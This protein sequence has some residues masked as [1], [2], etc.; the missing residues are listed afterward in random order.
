MQE[1][2]MTNAIAKSTSAESSQRIF[3]FLKSHSIGTLATVDSDNNPHATTIYFS[4]DEAFNIFF[5]TK[6]FTKKHETLQHNNH[7]M[8]VTHEAFT[9]TTAQVIGVAEEVVDT[10]LAEQIF[11]ETIKNA[12]KSTEA[13]VPPI[14]KL[15]AGDYIAYRIKP[16]E[17]RMAVYIRPDDGG[18][19]M[20]ET[21]EFED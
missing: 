2:S 13:G 8:L 4:I 7:V 10:T 11:K 16:S 12:V 17:I 1:N 21:I 5:T 20:F 14:S 3:S 6:R 19:D 9:Q 15:Y 18:Y